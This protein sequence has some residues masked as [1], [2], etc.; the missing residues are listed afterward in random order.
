[1]RVMIPYCGKKYC[2][3]SEKNKNEIIKKSSLL[4][5]KQVR[6]GSLQKYNLSF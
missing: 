4:R 5:N 2:Q 1:M 3:E 6:A